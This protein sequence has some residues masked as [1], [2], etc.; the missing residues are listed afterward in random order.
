MVTL[1][2]DVHFQYLA[3]P[4]PT[5]YVSYEI[6]LNNSNYDDVSIAVGN[7]E[8]DFCAINSAKFVG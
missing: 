2:K 3:Y 5:G 7:D 8:N 6:S 4:D 1:T